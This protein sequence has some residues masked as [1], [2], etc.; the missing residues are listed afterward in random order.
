MLIRKPDRYRPSEI[1]P[2]HFYH[3]RRRLLAGMLSMSAFALTNNATAA[4]PLAASPSAYTLKSQNYEALAPKKKAQGH[5]NFYELSTGKSDP[6]SNADWYKPEPWKV[7]VNGTVN[8]P[9]IF[10][11][12]DLAKL[13]PMEERIYRLRCVEA[14]SMVIP[15]IGFP[16]KALVNAVEPAAG[17]KYVSFITFNPET[18]FPDKANRSL[19]W[20]YIEALRLDEAINP[21]TLLVFGMYGERIPTQ[22]G[23]PVRLMIPW[24]Y[25][26]KSGKAPVKIVF[27]AEQPTTT[28][29]FI[30]PSEYGF[31]ANV[32]PM[33]DHPRWSQ[34]SERVID[35]SL[36][37]TRRP[38]E[39][40]NG[41]ADEVA[42]LY[43][44]MDLQKNF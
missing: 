4:T 33:A 26:F 36:F 18:L 35:D 20:P 12:D 34:A 13:A 1:T 10:D 28:W 32:N 7:E 25:G 39:M 31:Y 15:W 24:K 11:V 3:N 29:N 5:N 23:A 43:A 21:L 40:F 16:L 44:G 17:C 27:S 14:W 19:P 8:K 37:P 42:S 22:N 2:S 41:F 6:A 30:Q 9:R 38:T